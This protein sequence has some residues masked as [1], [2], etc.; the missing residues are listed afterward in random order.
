MTTSSSANDL[1]LGLVGPGRTRN[2]LGPFLAKHC[3]A[4]GARVVAVA[5]R[6]I[7]S[8][9]AAAAHLARD[10][11]HAIEAH[12]GVT[13]LVRRGDLAGLVIAAP[14]EAHLHA[15]RTALAARLPTLCEKPLVDVGEDAAALEVVEGFARQGILLVENCQW[16]FALAALRRRGAVPSSPPRSFAMRLSPTGHGRHMLV[17]A[18]SH[19]VSLLQALF[20][21]DPPG[22]GRGGELTLGGMRFS[23]RAADA[24]ATELDLEVHGAGG[25][26]TARLELVRCPHQPRPAWLAFDGERLVREIG[27]PAYQWQFRAGQSLYAI[28]DPQADLVYSFVQL[29]SQP[30][31]ELVRRHTAAI[32]CRARLFASIVRAFDGEP[33]DG[34]GG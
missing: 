10:L 30:S 2:G 1:R 20:A 27:Q 33:R 12:A 32:T 34:T 26:A 19:F 8:S 17:D 15:L 24:E 18:A 23:T 6:G 9:R 16:P 3:A 5:G 21:P 14:I 11:G 29:L 7:E 25:R 28:G 22:G 13:D 4:A 31:P